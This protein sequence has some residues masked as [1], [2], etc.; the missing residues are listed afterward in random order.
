MPKKAHSSKPGLLEKETPYEQ[1]DY[2]FHCYENIGINPKTAPVRG[3][4]RNQEDALAWAILKP[5]ELNGLDPVAIGH[6]LFSSYQELDA[7]ES[8]PYVGSTA[9][10]TVFDGKEHLITATV[11]DAVSYAAVYNK[12]GEVVHVKRLNSVLHH[13]TVSTEAGRIREA[14]GVVW[15][16]RVGGILAVSRAIGDHQYGKMVPADAQIDITSIPSLLSDA[17]IDRENVSEIKIITACDGLQE[18]VPAKHET[19]YL[20]EQLNLI[21]NGEP[22]SIAKK[23]VGAAMDMSLSASQRTRAS[24]D[25]ISVAIQSIFMDERINHPFIIGVYD[26]HGGNIV[27]RRIAEHIVNTFI[28]QCKL[29][30]RQYAV[31]KH[32]VYHDNHRDD[33]LRDHPQEKLTES[34]LLGGF[35][36]E[37][38]FELS[39]KSYISQHASFFLKACAENKPVAVLMT[40][41]FIAG[42]TLTLLVGLSALTTH[43]KIT[44]AMVATVTAIVGLLPPLCVGFEGMMR[45]KG[46]FFGEKSSEV[47]AARQDYKPSNLP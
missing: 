44:D 20:K 13:P 32:G 38:K 26:G 1:K 41:L 28:C 40:A 29:S 37:A 46:R 24:M 27:S 16:G 18:G 19:N 6:R 9:S 8:N 12:V 35:E 33:Y 3:E 39:E 22:L 47:T 30:H 7:Q 14:H 5:Q 45:Q 17:G 36:G 31:S 23:L 21:G 34:P 43:A 15:G 42:A 4:G 25:N 10:T 11:A 2:A